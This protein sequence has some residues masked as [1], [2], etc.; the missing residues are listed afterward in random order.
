MTARERTLEALAA[1][2]PQPAE[3]GEEIERAIDTVFYCGVASGATGEQLR[4]A[5]ANLVKAIRRWRTEGVEETIAALSQR[6]DRLAGELERAKSQLG[7]QAKLMVEDRYKH[8]QIAQRAETA[9]RELAEARA[10]LSRRFAI[11]GNLPTMT[12]A[13]LMDRFESALAKNTDLE[14]QLAE[15]RAAQPWTREALA[16]AVLSRPLRPQPTPAQTENAIEA[17]E[18]FAGYTHLARKDR[19][20]VSIRA[21]IAAYEKA[22]GAATPILDAGAPRHKEEPQPWT[23][24]GLTEALKNCKRQGELV[25]YEEL[26]AVALS[27]PLRQQPTAEQREK[28]IE[29]A[30]SVYRKRK[31]IAHGVRV[32]DPCD[33]CHEDAI[34]II[35]AYEKAITEQSTQPPLSER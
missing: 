28:A 24:E 22:L 5:H 34:A 19:S 7:T 16:R 35:A 21:I 1:D 13:D 8:S 23:M 30:T 33:R 29:A 25:T 26:A 15:S 4:T 27:R 9:E 6:S 3:V 11:T 18:T 31:L 2:Q 20:L 32:T 10:A 17:A 14:R 12:A